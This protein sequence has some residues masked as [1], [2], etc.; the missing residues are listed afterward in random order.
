MHLLLC[1]F[2]LLSGG[3]CVSCNFFLSVPMLFC[4]TLYTVNNMPEYLTDSCLF[5]FLRHNLN[6]VFLND[7]RFVHLMESGRVGATTAKR[8]PRTG[9]LEHV[10]P[11]R[12]HDDGR[13]NI[14]LYLQNYVQK[15]RHAHNVHSHS[16]PI[17]EDLSSNLWAVLVALVF[18]WPSSMTAQMMSVLSTIRYITSDSSTFVK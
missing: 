1:M 16:C 10:W 11:S 8:F 14:Q 3:K 17:T 2:V 6:F 13:T 9:L 12:Y 7:V 5:W 15:R 4:L 18:Y